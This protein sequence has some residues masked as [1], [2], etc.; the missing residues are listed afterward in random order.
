MSKFIAT[1]VNRQWPA[2]LDVQIKTFETNDRGGP[3]SAELACSGQ[4][5]AL[6]GLIPL[7]GQ[8]I[9]IVNQHGNTVWHGLIQ[10]ISGVVEGNSIG[11]TLKT[12]FNRI[13]VEYSAPDETGASQSYTTDWLDNLDSQQ[14]YGIRE[15]ILSIGEAN[16][17]IASRRR[18]LYLQQHAWPALTGKG[19][20][21]SPSALTMTCIGLAQTLTYR[22]VQFLRGRLVNEPTTRTTQLIGW[23]RTGNDIGMSSAGIYDNSSRLSPLQTG[24]RI[25]LTGS[26]W[27]NNYYSIK[28]PSNTQTLQVVSDQFDYDNPDDIYDW[29]DGLSDVRANTWI[30]I[31]NS[32]K[33]NGYWYIKQVTPPD[34]LTISGSASG[35]SLNDGPDDSPTATLTQGQS[36]GV[37]VTLRIVKPAL[38]TI[39]IELFGTR[40]AQRFQVTDSS[41]IL[42]SMALYLGKAG[43]PSDTLRIAFYSDASGTPGSQFA[44]RIVAPAEIY[45]DTQPSETW[46]SLPNL[47]LAAGYYWIVIERTGAQS[48]SDYFMLS[49]SKHSYLSTLAWT[50]TDWTELN[51]RD[52]P[53]V[54]QYSVPFRLYDTEDTSI[55]MQ[56]IIAS[57]PSN[58]VT[59]IFIQPTGVMTN[60]YIDNKGTALDELTA[61]LNAGD[62]AGQRLVMDCK[63]NGS[64]HIYP[65]TNTPTIAATPVLHRDGAIYSPN[66]ARHPVGIVPVGNYMTLPGVPQTINDTWRLSPVYIA[67]ARYNAE[68]DDFTYQTAADEDN[69]LLF[70]T[71]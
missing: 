53:T 69:S 6:W 5:N 15:K 42:G 11:V 38:S 56:R 27:G 39:D 44:E 36:V 57:F 26:T 63:P 70:L 23:R 47:T 50:G 29:N 64:L 45:E 1:P 60:S 52:L 48:D 62:S 12:C 18:A 24:D 55:T 3:V 31:T 14:Q 28:S 37:N 7:I 68:N 8:Q 51:Y 10:T 34:K 54:T 32:S 9:V 30:A 21:A 20:S 22:R 59:S 2:G 49:L 65:I 41:I 61:L 58:L 33:N 66:G 43:T 35:A 13:A 67:T 16:P 71:T 19:W 25:R 46:L 17:E 40:V 4:D